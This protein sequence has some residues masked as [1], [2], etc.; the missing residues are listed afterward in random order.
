MATDRAAR[1][2]RSREDPK[3]AS[4]MEL[5]FD[6]AFIFALAELTRALR[7]DTSAGGIL[8]TLLLL[9]AVWWVWTVTAWSSDWFSPDSAF[10]RGLLAWVMFGGLLMAAAVPQAFGRYA[11]VFAGAYVIVHIGRGAGLMFA[12]SGHPAQVR[13]LRV[14]VWFLATG[15][16]WI[17][18]ALAPSVREPLWAVAILVDVT[19]GL[20]GYPVPGLGHSTQQDLRVV[21]EHFAERYEQF[22]IVAIGELILVTGIAFLDAGFAWPHTIAFALSFL[23]ALLYTEIYHAPIATGLPA[24]LSRSRNPARLAVVAGY[25]HLMVLAGILAT[26]VGNEMIILGATGKNQTAFAHI[27]GAGAFVYLLSRVLPA[28]IA[29]HRMPWSRVV[30]LVA[31]VGVK[32]VTIHLPPIATTA[33]VDLILLLIAVTDHARPLRRDPGPARR[34]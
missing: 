28:V 22:F 32:P 24:A 16:L 7:G 19:I 13:S 6:L 1:L 26:A 18:G 5:F 8:R 10:V 27:L 4:Y 31:M 33:A 30:G 12:L 3:R 14:M 15:V 9:A 11:L 20:F 25:V 17:G 21:P 23:N 2:L 34:G 29:D